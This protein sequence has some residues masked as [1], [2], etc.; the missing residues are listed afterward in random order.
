MGV[1]ERLQLDEGSNSPRLRGVQFSPLTPVAVLIAQLAARCSGIPRDRSTCRSARGSDPLAAESAE[2]P[3]ERPP[4]TS[5]G[6]GEPPAGSDGNS[7]VR[8][9]AIRL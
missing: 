4:L 2:P 9:G 1:V 7:W 6:G 8:R 5:A 3:G